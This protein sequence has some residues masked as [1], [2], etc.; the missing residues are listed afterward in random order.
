[1]AA[2]GSHVGTAALANVSSFGEVAGAIDHGALLV[3]LRDLY[4]L[5]TVIGVITLI[6]ITMGHFRRHVRSTYPTLRQV[7]D[8]LRRKDRRR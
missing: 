7:Y 4:G 2:L 3:S 5:A 1:M 6:L 8:I